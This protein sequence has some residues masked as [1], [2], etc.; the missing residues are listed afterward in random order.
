MTRDEI[1]EGLE[2]EIR[3]IHR[4]PKGKMLGIFMTVDEAE[5]IVALLKEQEEREG[6]KPLLAVSGFVCGHCGHLIAKHNEKLPEKC[7]ACG[8]YVGSLI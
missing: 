3:R 6:V 8:T 4:E 5:D 2:N 7:D 1:I